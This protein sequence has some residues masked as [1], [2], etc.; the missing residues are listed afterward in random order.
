AVHGRKALTLGQKRRP[1][2]RGGIAT[3]L[4]PSPFMGTRSEISSRPFD[5][6]DTRMPEALSWTGGRALQSKNTEPRSARPAA[7]SRYSFQGI[8]SAIT[9]LLIR[10]LEGGRGRL[11]QAINYQHLT[12]SIV[13]AWLAVVVGLND[14]QAQVRRQSP[15]FSAAVM[16]AQGTQNEWTPHD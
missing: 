11:R 16:T 15:G 8:R 3:P 9:L 4:D 12:V 2:A 1:T 14:G 5:A 10:A 13:V 6:A 7:Q